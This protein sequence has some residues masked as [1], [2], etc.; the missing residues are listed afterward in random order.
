MF[1]MLAKKCFRGYTWWYGLA[2]GSPSFVVALQ[3]LAWQNQGPN[4]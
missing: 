2:V 1:E 4:S 3:T